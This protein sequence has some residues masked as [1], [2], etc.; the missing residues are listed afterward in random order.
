MFDKTKKSK[1]IP[2][3][4]S[5]EEFM[6]KLQESIGSNMKKC[7]I[8]GAWIPKE[9]ISCPSCGSSSLTIG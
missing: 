5:P 1:S 6:K 8:C 2:V 9:V 3:K 7:N 4:A